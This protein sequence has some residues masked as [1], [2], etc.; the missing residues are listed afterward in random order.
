MQY[1]ENT[2][3]GTGY[4]FYDLTPEAVYGTVGWAVSTYYDRKHHIKMMQTRAMQQHFSWMDAAKQYELLY[5]KAR[6]R[7]SVWH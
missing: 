2:G 4:L 6:L 5:R 1:D 7:R 3:S